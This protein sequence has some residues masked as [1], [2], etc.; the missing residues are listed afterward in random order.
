[1]FILIFT[2][3]SG[4]NHAKPPLSGS[5]T[6]KNYGETE[7]C[8]A[9]CIDKYKFPD[10]SIVKSYN[11][12]FNGNIWSKIEIIPDCEPAIPGIGCNIVI[13]Q[14]QFSVCVTDPRV[15]RC[16]SE[17]IDGYNYPDGSKEIIT[18][19]TKSDGKYDPVKEIPDC[20]IAGVEDT[21]DKSSTEANNF[22]P[23][24]EDTE[25]KNSTEANI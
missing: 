11:C 18:T 3:C 19:C 22:E 9:T 14:K 13:G 24:V 5:L 10:G 2:N 1:M 8:Q 6:C 23:G 15:Q 4:C 20:E 7:F 12:S 25:D 17:C 16:R 21:E